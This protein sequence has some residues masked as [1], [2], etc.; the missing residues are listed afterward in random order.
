MAKTTLRFLAIAD[1]TISGDTIR[2]D[3]PSQKHR[4]RTI[5]SSRVS[6]FLSEANSNFLAQ[7]K[8]DFSKSDLITPLPIEHNNSHLL[9]QRPYTIAYKKL[10]RPRH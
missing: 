2:M 7:M 4:H 8:V 6:I 5:A 3:T 10:R 1:N 9:L